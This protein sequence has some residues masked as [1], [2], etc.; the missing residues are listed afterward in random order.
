MAK[1]NIIPSSRLMINYETSVDGVLKKKELPYRV[2]VAGDLSK[3]KS[4][5]AQKDLADRD[6]RRIKHGADRALEDM[7]ISFDF[8]VP[9][10]VSKESKSLKVNYKL[11]AIKD[12]KPDAVAQKVP[13]IK[14]LLELKEILTSFAKDI[15]NNRNL[16]KVIDGVFSDKSE[17][18]VLKKK[19][20][21]LA[22]YS[23]EYSEEN[24]IKGDK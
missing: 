7:N 11:D 21:N 23:I 17:L 14:A 3:G 22:N 4:S 1:K 5:D 20:P 12:F 24:E 16:K 15:D 19:I 2:L 13:E 10:F 9:N 6:V 18:E 8:E